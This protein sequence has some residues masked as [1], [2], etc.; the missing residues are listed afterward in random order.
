MPLS[1]H[2]N[3][4][5]EVLRAGGYFVSDAEYR[6][7]LVDL[8][9]VDHVTVEGFGHRGRA[10]AARREL[11]AAGFMIDENMDGRNFIIGRLIENDS[12]EATS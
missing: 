3:A 2:A 5:L 1:K 7:T 11:K 4:A 6:N 12:P 9:T 10:K 8:K